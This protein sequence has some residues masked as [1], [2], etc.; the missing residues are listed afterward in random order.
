MLLENNFSD[1]WLETNLDPI[2]VW[3]YVLE[4]HID[5]AKLKA[6]FE[7][8]VQRFPV[9]SARMYKSGRRLI[10]PNNNPGSILWT[11]L[12]HNKSIPE[13]FAP[14]PSASDRILVSS[15]DLETRISLY[16]PGGINRLTRKGSAGKDWP[17]VEICI[18][19][20]IDKMVIGIAWNHLVMDGGGMA[21]VVSSW[22]KALRG[23]ALPE[24]V[25]CND[26]FKD[27]LPPSL[28]RP[29]GSAIPIYFRYM[30]LVFRL[31]LDSIRDGS[32]EIRTIF[33][34]NSILTEWKE[35]SNDVSANDILTAWICKAWASTITSKSLTVSIGI[36]MDLR[37]HLSDVTPKSYLRNAAFLALSP[38]KLTTHEIN[39]MSHLQVAQLIRS[40]LKSNTPEA[41]LN[42]IAYEMKVP[43]GGF[44][45]MAKED[46][47]FL[48]TSWSKFN[49][50]GMDFGAKIESFE[51]MTQVYRNMSNAGS[52]W[53]EEGG[54]R[55]IFMMSRKKWTRGIWRGLSKG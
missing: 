15:F 32:T 53:L 10:L 22:T 49:L 8:V 38:Q 52:I 33:I 50:P 12:N 3:G 7:S 11:V 27:N 36:P 6:A 13:V 17:L 16:F 20:F 39:N 29:I 30:R 34:P 54:A 43:L 41:L 14:L 55:L 48:I 18:Q 26:I 2:V 9:L 42:N 24:V 46:T 19:R 5:T 44:G 31:I 1:R 51:G 25:S 47:F 40:F 4:S 21:V 35:N 28:T 37:K 23:E 45:L